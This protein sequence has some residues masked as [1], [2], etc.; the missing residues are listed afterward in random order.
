M[1]RASS[2]LLLVIAMAMAPVTRGESPPQGSIAFVDMNIIPMDQ[3]RVLRHQTLLVKNGVILALGPSDSVKVPDD[4]KRVAGEPD[5]YLVPGL[6][7]MHVHVQQEDDLSL[8]VANGVTTL[9]HMGNAPTG[10]VTGVPRDI[11]A[12]KLVGPRMFFGFLVDGSDEYGFFFVT[13]PEEAHGL[14][15]LAKTN[16]Y[17]F[18]KVYN[19]ISAPVF[20]ALVDEGRKLG[21]AVIGHGVLAV[22]LPEALFRGQIMVAHGEEFIYTAFH[23]KVDQSKIAAV[24]SETRRS[25]AY[26]TP[27]L[28][29]F[30]VIANQWGK[31]EVLAA[32]LKDPKARNMTPSQRL[33]W[34]HSRYVTRKGSID[35]H[36]IFLRIF[37][38]ALS[39]AGVPLL[40]GTD[41]PSIPGMYPGYSEHEDL[42]T[43]VEA[44]L[45]N[46]E[47]LSAAT[48]VPGE[49]IHKFVP[50]APTFGTLK[51]GLRGD[52][53]LVSGNPLESLEKLRSPKGVLA[54]GRWFSAADLSTLLERHRKAFDSL[55]Q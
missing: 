11:A 35:D 25:N 8:Y 14:V 9:L 38:K 55:L 53:V 45:T 22:G 23:D 31:P 19:H 28:S 4:A 41:S 18:I 51:V 16:G 43:L 3:E 2:L 27:N 30:E 33:G 29:A 32:F 47:A 10:F 20:D 36:L 34:T 24:V 54:D 39:K 48:R 46:Y 7:D 40:T 44:G 21:M 52:A 1:N 50:E 17:A 42:R 12:G 26:V 37:T 13:Q 6:A 15:R 5:D 49:F